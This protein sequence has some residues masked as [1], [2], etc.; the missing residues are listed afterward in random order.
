MGSGSEGD[1][2]KRGRRDWMMVRSAMI[3]W[4]A[5]SDERL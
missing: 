5:V 2:G 1:G 4:N 3:F